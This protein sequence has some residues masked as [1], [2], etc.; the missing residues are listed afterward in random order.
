MFM[1][2]EAEG[3]NCVILQHRVDLSVFVLRHVAH[4]V[5]MLLFRTVQ[6]SGEQCHVL[7]VT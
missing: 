4:F 7:G 1:T 3:P 6:G 5:V 2:L